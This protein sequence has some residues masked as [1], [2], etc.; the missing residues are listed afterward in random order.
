MTT[1]TRNP[2]EVHPNKED[3]PKSN[4]APPD[5]EPSLTANNTRR[6]LD[7]TA[8]PERIPRRDCTT[9]PERIP[10]SAPQEPTQCARVRSQLGALSVAVSR[11]VGRGAW[12]AADNS[13]SFQRNTSDGQR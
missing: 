1:S 2:L 4:S 12:P 6:Q 5:P 7:C 9:R 8:R 10:R 13:T 11:V 3:D